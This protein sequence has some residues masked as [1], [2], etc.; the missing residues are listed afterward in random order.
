MHT[1]YMTPNSK[2]RLPEDFD[3][4]NKQESVKAA[5]KRKRKRKKMKDGQQARKYSQGQNECS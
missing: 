5:M 4:G 1:R 2:S 3:S